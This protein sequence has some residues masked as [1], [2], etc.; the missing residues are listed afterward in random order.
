MD[1]IRMEEL[2]DGT[3]GLHTSD[4]GAK[5]QVAPKRPAEPLSE[6]ERELERIAKSMEVEIDYSE[7]VEPDLIYAAFRGLKWTSARGKDRTSTAC[8]FI[9]TS[10]RR[11]ITSDEGLYRTVFSRTWA[12]MLESKT[13]YTVEYNTQEY[14]GLI[15][16]YT[17]RTNKAEADV[18][19]SR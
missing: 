14:D 16:K 18:A 8:V 4:Y 15:A 5:N 9:D 2:A 3:V 12:I 11:L 6:W 10:R 7:L 1:V 13:G 17:K 19:Y